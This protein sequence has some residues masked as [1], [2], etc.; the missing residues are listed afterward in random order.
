[1]IGRTTATTS[2]AYWGS[3]ERSSGR[4]RLTLTTADFA[5]NGSPCSAV[6]RAICFGS[7]RTRKHS[8]SL[9]YPTTVDPSLTLGL[10]ALLLRGYGNILYLRSVTGRTIE[11]AQAHF[12]VAAGWTELQ[13]GL[14]RGVFA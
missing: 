3:G 1:M 8:T 11:W 10:P 4:L 9:I 5:G 2:T 7:R 13:T 6:P 14:G 12:F